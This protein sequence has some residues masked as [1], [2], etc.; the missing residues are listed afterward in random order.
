MLENV[1]ATP[2]PRPEQDIH[3]SLKNKRPIWV[4]L[5][6]RVSF[7]VLIRL[8]TFLITR[9]IVSA[10]FDG[11]NGLALKPKLLTVDTETL[12]LD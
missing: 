1:Q 7:V 8:E 12:N 6:P 10:K 5:P 2:P 9:K 3:T 11:G 4:P